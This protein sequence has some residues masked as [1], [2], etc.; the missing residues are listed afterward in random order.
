MQL[1]QVFLWCTNENHIQEEHEMAIEKKSLR[2]N[3]KIAKKVKNGP[4]KNAVAS[5]GQKMTNF[6]TA[7]AFD[8]DQVL[9]P[10]SQSGG[11]GAGKIA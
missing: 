8:V 1:R 5:R 3:A 2:H 10:G 4:T 6:K 7:P 9:N 11:I